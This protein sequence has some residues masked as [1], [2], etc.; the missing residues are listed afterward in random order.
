VNINGILY[1]VKI[2]QDAGLNSLN[3]NNLVAAQNL[4]NPVAEIPNSIRDTASKAVKHFVS[5]SRSLTLRSGVQLRS[6]SKSAWLPEAIVGV[7]KSENTF[8]L[9]P[10]PTNE[11]F[12]LSLQQGDY[13]VEVFDAL[14]KLIFAKNTEGGITNIDVRTWHNG[15]YMVSCLDKTTKQKTFSKVVVQH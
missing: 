10:N 13:A 2:Q 9:S 8:V 12:D 14:G 5:V 3:Q 1:D 15:I 4:L 7:V 6:S 11:Q